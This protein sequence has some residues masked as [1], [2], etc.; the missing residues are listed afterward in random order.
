M[1]FPFYTKQID[2][3]N[4]VI[5]IFKDQKVIELDILIDLPN[6]DRKF[7]EYF[8]ELIRRYPNKI[9]MIRDTIN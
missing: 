6:D 7:H 3:K 4:R 1:S 2:G 8:K 5:I 9:E